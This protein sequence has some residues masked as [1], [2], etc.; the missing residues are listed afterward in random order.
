[1][2]CFAGNGLLLR[3]EALD[4]V[5]GWNEDALTEDI[6]LS[7]RF[8]LVGWEIRYC[9]EAIVWEGGV[10][11]L[12][13]LRRPRASPA[14]GQAAIAGWLVVRVPPESRSRLPAAGLFLARSAAF[15]LA[16]LI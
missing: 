15:S 3:R 4:E 7:V 13:T 11:H 6:D 14:W 2:V 8:H 1:M 5:G 16:R 12:R 10:V 9:D